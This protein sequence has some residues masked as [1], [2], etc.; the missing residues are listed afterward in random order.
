VAASGED[1]EP[2][3]PSPEPPDGI[4]EAIREL[5]RSGV[6]DQLEE[7]RPTFDLFEQEKL[8]ELELKESYGKNLLRGMFLQL[9]VA[10]AVFVAY[11]WYG[12]HWKL[13]PSV[14]EIWLAATVVRMVGVVYVVTRNLFPPKKD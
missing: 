7:L 4:R 3:E 1:E 13:D 14:I 12:K 5:V 2:G 8:Q 6:A 11:A 9:F 10:D